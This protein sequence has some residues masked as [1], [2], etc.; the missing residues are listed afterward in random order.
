MYFVCH[1]CSRL[2]GYKQTPLFTKT[3]FYGVSV[4]VVVVSWDVASELSLSPCVAVRGQSPLITARPFL[5]AGPTS[6]PFVHILSLKPLAS[7]SQH[8]VTI[9]II[10]DLCLLR[11]S[12]SGQYG[13]VYEALWKPRNMLVAVKTLKVSYFPPHNRHCYA[14]I[15]FFVYGDSSRVRGR[16]FHP[17]FVWLEKC[18]RVDRGFPV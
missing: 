4:A 13:I 1:H 9:I 14:L 12:G 11:F 7:F 17:I 2:L 16:Q 5:R 8:D 6:P 3:S 18:S 15:V 10:I